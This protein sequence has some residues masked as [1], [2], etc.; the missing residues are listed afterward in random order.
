MQ[1]MMMQMQMGQTEEPEMGPGG[2]MSGNGQVP[3]M[4]NNPG[5]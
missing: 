5:V 2:T 4:T 3:D 1:Q